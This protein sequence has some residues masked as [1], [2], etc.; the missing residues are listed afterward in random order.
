MATKSKKIGDVFVTPTGL[1]VGSKG[2]VLPAGKF[3]G[4]LAK[5]EARRLRKELRRLGEVKKAGA[6]RM[7]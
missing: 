2:K 1:K 6:A 5:G 4:S 3:L 7:A